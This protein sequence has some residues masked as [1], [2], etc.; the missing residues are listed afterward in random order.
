MSTLRKYQIILLACVVCMIIFLIAFN[1]QRTNNQVPQQLKEADYEQAINRALVYIERNPN[2]ISALQWFFVDYLQRKFDL[3]P[4]FRA[5]ARNLK[6]PSDKNENLQF[7]IHQRIINPQALVK[8]LELSKNDSMDNM[9]RM[10]THCDHI[11][12]PA[13]YDALLQNNINA[14]GY[15]M[16]HA[17]YSLTRIKELNCP[18][19]S[20]YDEMLAQLT[21]Q[22][23]ELASNP[24]TPN[25]LR[26][27]ATAFLYDMGRGDQVRV[28][29][30]NRIVS[31]QQPDGSWENSEDEQ[32]NHDH[33]TI[34]ALWS[35]L[36][37]SRDDVASKPIL[38]K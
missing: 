25:D 8:E 12:L 5:A 21:S 26:Y 35:L 34:L 37:S 32:A 2:E 18:K 33:T 29:W 38:R 20:R 9:V 4:K 10:A 13:N 31:E 16:T 19:P 15:E 6:P 7:Q 24:K 17:A 36:E 23:A 28:E 30:I 11:D 1:H 22:L 27:E 14:G 3:D